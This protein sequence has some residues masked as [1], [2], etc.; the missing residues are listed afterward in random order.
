MSE[1]LDALWMIVG[2]HGGPAAV[3]DGEPDWWLHQIVAGGQVIGDAGFHGPPGQSSPRTVEIG[4]NVVGSM[5]RR[6]VA[7][8]AC[9]LLLEQAWRDGADVV[10]AEADPTNIGSHRVLGRAGFV[11]DDELRYRISRPSPGAGAPSVAADP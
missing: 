7:T 11:A 9:R 5:R 10:V 4:Y 1:T 2:A 8:H 3:A 6:G